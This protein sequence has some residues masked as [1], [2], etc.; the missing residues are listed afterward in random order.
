MSKM[1]QSRTCTAFAVALIAMTLSAC[2]TLRG[3]H[4]EGP[5]SYTAQGDRGPSSGPSVKLAGDSQLSRDDGAPKLD[6]PVDEARMTRG[7]FFGN[8]A[9]YGLDLANRRGTAVMAAGV[10]TV[11]YA[12]RQFHGFGRLIVV[13]HSPGWA[14]FYAHLDK[15]LVRE[16]DKV[17]SGEKIGLM[18]STGHAHG[19]HLHFEVRHRSQPVNPLAYLPE[20][21]SAISQR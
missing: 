6:W 4:F 15:I 17:T 1:L 10:G 12:G 9:H 16:G 11:I 20:S 21:F 13:E 14:T 18:G 5:G 19:V 2:G 7:F 8:K 3:P